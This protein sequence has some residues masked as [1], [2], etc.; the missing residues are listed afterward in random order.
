M[1]VLARVGF[2]LFGLVVLLGIVWLF[3]NNKRRVDWRLVG[4]GLV[5]QVVIACVVLL[6]PWGAGFFD[7]LSAGFV[8][9][10]GFT[11][12]GARFIFGDFSGYRIVDRVGLSV[13]VDPFSR[14]KNGITVFHCR[15][16]VGG[17]VTD[18]LKFIKVKVG[19]AG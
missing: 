17:D 13:L 8:T 5:L 10:L 12:Q 11:T 3:S 18:P 1:E 15:K 6:T 7:G 19:T 16:R 14:A 9:L 2:G 4:T